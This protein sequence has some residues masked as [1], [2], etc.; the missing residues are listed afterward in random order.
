MTNG[1]RTQAPQMRNTATI[2]AELRRLYR[3]W[4]VAREMGCTPN[5]AFIDALLDERS[6]T[7]S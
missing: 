3:A 7:M 1:V 2:D 6:E 4:R 5:T